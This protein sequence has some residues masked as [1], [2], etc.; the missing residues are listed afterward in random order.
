MHNIIFL[1]CILFFVPG[2]TIKTSD[3]SIILN[4]GKVVSIC[5]RKGGS[6]ICNILDSNGDVSI[7]QNWQTCN[8][9]IGTIRPQFCLDAM[10]ALLGQITAML[11]LQSIPHWITQG[12]LLGAVRSGSVIAWANDVDLHVRYEDFQAVLDV[13]ASATKSHNNVGIEDY[14][15]GNWE[16]MVYSVHEELPSKI[17]PTGSKWVAVNSG[18][19]YVLLISNLFLFRTKFC[20]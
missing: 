2:S 5:E 16:G 17:Y 12:T 6:K 10:I 9:P 13:L 20:M 18:I 8:L 1:F 3:T 19:V 14:V 7:Q 15:Y 4:P 11:E